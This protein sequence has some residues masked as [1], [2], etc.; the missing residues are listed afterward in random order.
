M[1][2]TTIIAIMCLMMSLSA[3]ATKLVI[4]HEDF[5]LLT[6]R[7]K[8]QYIIKL[9][10][11][12]IELESRYARETA[13]HGYSKERFERYSKILNQLKSALFIPEAY[14]DSRGG[15]R[16]SPTV[17]GGGTVRSAPVKAAVKD[18][19]TWEQMATD[20]N[21][22]LSEKRDG[23]DNCI[24]AGWISRTVM[25]NGKPT[26][27]HPDFIDGDSP[28]RH[29]TPGGMIARESFAYPDPQ[30]GSNCGKNDK[31]MIQCNP[32]IFGYKKQSSKTLICVKAG[33]D[34]H[35]SSFNCMKAALNPEAS[36]AEQD[37]AANRLKF[38]RDKFSDPKNAQLFK[39][40]WGFTFKT[41]LCESPASGTFSQSYQNYMRPHQTCYGLMEMMAETSAS[42]TPQDKF[43]MADTTI[44]KKLQEMIKRTGLTETQAKDQYSSFL[45]TLKQNNSKEYTDVC[46]GTPSIVVTPKEEVPVIVPKEE[47]PVVDPPKEPKYA[48]TEAKCESSEKVTGAGTDGTEI[49]TTE[50]TCSFT[51]KDE[52]NAS[53]TPAFESTPT[54]KPDKPDATSLS[55]KNKIGGKDVTLSCP[56]K[57]EP[58]KV[59]PSTT[60]DPD[61]TLSTKIEC[62]DKSCKITAIPEGKKDGD[63]WSVKWNI[64][65]PPQGETIAKDWEKPEDKPTVLPG[66]VNDPAQK[67]ETTPAADKLEITQQKGKVAYV[68]CATLEKGDKKIPDGGSCQ[69]VPALTEAPKAPAKP[70]AGAANGQPN[71]TLAPPQVQIR[72]SSD[73][74]AIGIK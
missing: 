72:G 21:K 70:A 41:C 19:R 25:K 54:E 63:G 44:F 34:S 28:N 11:M 57:V 32:L 12:S 68:V 53:A 61:P 59:T 22:L 18:P 55:V 16:V 29:I 51:L 47:V 7:E 74:S 6:D 30:P 27:T 36:E 58:K 23:K 9:M 65:D 40:V 69:T 24:F 62:V 20:W 73:T 39:D 45:T 46:G 8:D 15:A 48:C 1:L 13:A 37:S 52:N 38:L 67:Q 43:P 10:E 31:S 50:Y 71:P 5:I 33:D 42:C 3:G 64:K 35:N 14:A 4:T 60:S 26:C 2:K 49:K 66:Q 56:L 17:K